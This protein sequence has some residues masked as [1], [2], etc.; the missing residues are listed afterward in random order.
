M[1][2]IATGQPYIESSLSSRILCIVFKKLGPLGDFSFHGAGHSRYW[3][4]IYKEFRRL[5]RRLAT[6]SR[7]SCLCA[8]LLLILILLGTVHPFKLHTSSPHKSQ[9][10]EE[11]SETALYTEMQSWA[12]TMNIY[13]ESL[14]RLYII[15]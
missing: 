6:V 2:V 15:V 12:E 9:E 4:P 3:G 7:L 1:C 8:L 11:R 10:S 5:E 13:F 14:E